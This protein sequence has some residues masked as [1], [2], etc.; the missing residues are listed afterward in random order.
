MK[1]I[2]EID[3]EIVVH[4][5]LYLSLIVLSQPLVLGLGILHLAVAGSYL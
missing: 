2:L 3:R 4:M 1:V 5:R